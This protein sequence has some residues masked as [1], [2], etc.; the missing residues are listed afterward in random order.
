MSRIAQVFHV[1]RKD[2]R[3]YWP[4]VGFLTLVLT[5][6]AF[7]PADQT[8]Y[9][10]GG[11]IG[12]MLGGA[13]LRGSILTLVMIL[14]AALV[15]QEDNVSHRSAFWSSRPFSPMA[16]LA[17]KG[18]FL[19]LFLLALPLTFQAVAILEFGTTDG[20]AGHLAQSAFFHG[21]L[22]AVVVALAAVTRDLKGTLF[23]GL[24]GYAG[25]S[26]L[27]SLLRAPTN[28]ITLGPGPD[29]AV[30]IF[31]LVAALSIIAFQYGTRRTRQTIWGLGVFLVLT[32]VLVMR[33]ADRGERTTTFFEVHALEGEVPVP[34]MVVQSLEFAPGKRST[35][36]AGIDR[37]DAVIATADTELSIVPRMATL[38][39]RVQ[40]TDGRDERSTPRG[41]LYNPD[42]RYAPLIDGYEWLGGAGEWAHFDVPILSAPAGTLAPT[43]NAIERIQLSTEWDAFKRVPLGRLSFGEEDSFTAGPIRMRV[44]SVTYGEEELE[45]ALEATWVTESRARFGAEPPVGTI[46]VIAVNDDR[47]QYLLGSSGGNSR[48]SISLV[49]PGPQA[50]KYSINLRYRLDT[51]SGEGVARD[52]FEGAEIL[53]YTNEYVGTFQSTMDSDLGDLAQ[54]TISP[55]AV[56]LESAARMPD[57]SVGSARL[58]EARR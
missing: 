14:I 15:I 29:V 39:L 41:R 32:P 21:G 6:D 45:V 11:A 2:L 7:L 37:I 46:R 10:G 26:V 9:F 54:A 44:Q 43:M 35:R 42:Q 36:G 51:E 5:A 1:F 49:L 40:T 27:G 31:V 25:K 19:S 8:R 24:A 30:D 13:G 38:E 17:A 4:L 28:V 16:V 48:S 22:L 12:A 20:L 3:R 18:L 53:V 50:I 33:F 52:W 47:K 23:L 57:S 56:V 55:G 34:E 58:V